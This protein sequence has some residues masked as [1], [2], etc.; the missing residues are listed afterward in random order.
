[1][2]KDLP[3][4]RAETAENESTTRGLQELIHGHQPRRQA[5]VDRVQTGKVNHHPRGGVAPNE[6]GN[7]L[8]DFL[9]FRSSFGEN[10]Q[11]DVNS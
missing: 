9:R 5:A 8:L 2:E 6:R 11:D 4:N 3:D 10:L 1:M 7:K